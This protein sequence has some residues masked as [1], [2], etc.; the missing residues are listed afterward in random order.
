MAFQLPTQAV[1][2]QN[3]GIK[4]KNQSNFLDPHI[5]ICDEDYEEIS[6]HGKECDRDTCI[7][8]ALNEWEKKCEEEINHDIW[9]CDDDDDHPSGKWNSY[10]V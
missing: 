3:A 7:Q 6:P 1:C 4:T 9:I 8:R 2:K 5:W 10:S